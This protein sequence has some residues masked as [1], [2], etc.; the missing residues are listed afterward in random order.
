[1]FFSLEKNTKLFPTYDA[2]RD[3]LS[4][5]YVYKIFYDFFYEINTM[6]IYQMYK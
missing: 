4:I 6:F 2:T 3:R 5:E 1:M